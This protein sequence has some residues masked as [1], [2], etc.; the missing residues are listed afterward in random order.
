MAVYLHFIVAYVG[1][2]V[3]IIETLFRTIL[4]QTIY[5]KGTRGMGQL[6]DNLIHKLKILRGLTFIGMLS[7]C[8]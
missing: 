5:G 1:N 3:Y 2:T 6:L 8:R 7:I 4:I